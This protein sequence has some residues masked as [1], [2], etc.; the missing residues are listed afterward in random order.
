M[1]KITPCLWFDNEAEEAAN[2][3]CSIFNDSKILNVSRYG[4]S[5]PGPAGSAIMV[6]FQL[7]GQRFLGL[8]GGSH[9]TFTPAI[10]LMV[11]CRTQEEVDAYWNKLSAHPE[12]EQC[13]WLKDKYGLSWQIVPKAL[14]ELM[15]DPD[16]VKSQNV[17]KAMLQMKKL[18]IAALQAAHDR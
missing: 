6:E 1:Q 5:G 4:E 7:E 14:G 15:S 3:Y 17:M 16:P 13:G 9:F 10:S 8:N 11:D 18:D 12:A 2:F